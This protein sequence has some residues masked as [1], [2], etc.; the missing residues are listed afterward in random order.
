MNYSS[1]VIES[2]G[3]A[4][5]LTLRKQRQPTAKPSRPSSRQSLVLVGGPDDALAY[6]QQLDGLV[7]QD[8][9]PFPDEALVTLVLN[10]VDRVGARTSTA[11]VERALRS[12]GGGA[13]LVERLAAALGA[14]D[15]PSA[16]PALA[17]WREPFQLP[18][19]VGVT[20]VDWDAQRWRFGLTADGIGLW[21]VTKPAGPIEEFSGDEAG[22]AQ[23]DVRAWELIGRAIAEHTHISE[24]VFACAVEPVSFDDDFPD[25]FVDA[26]V[27]TEDIPGW[28]LAVNIDPATGVM[29]VFHID[30]DD[31]IKTRL[32]APRDTKVY[33]KGMDIGGRLTPVHVKDLRHLANIW[34]ELGNCGGG[35]PGAWIAVDSEITLVELAERV[36]ALT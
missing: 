5:A 17:G 8:L 1:L 32:A 13:E 29:A 35:V 16:E 33:S 34:S 22:H 15:A 18:L 36:R 27:A 10:F 4:D 25:D 23:V 2:D 14:E 12:P 26:T 28:R 31:L 11:E 7:V 6:R 24:P 21:D 3:T 19:Y 20:L 9:A 30:E